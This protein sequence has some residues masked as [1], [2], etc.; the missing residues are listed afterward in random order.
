MFVYKIDEDLS[1]RLLNTYDA[2]EFFQLMDTSRKH[3]SKW[4]G[5]LDYNKEVNDSKAFIEATLKSI[6]DTGG[7]PKTVAMIYKGS[8]AGVIGFN[9][10]NHSNKSAIIGY[11]IGEKFQGKGI[12]TKACNALIVYGFNDIRLNRMEIRVAKENY[13]S[14]AIPERLGFKE[15]GLIRH[16][17]WLYDHYVDHVV[18]GLLKEE[19]QA[20]TDKDFNQKKLETR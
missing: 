13:K 12:V 11:W 8:I 5:W 19:W 2:E 1:L 7:F 15:E 18:Y 14:R 17:E 20:L 10:I 3:L 6:A 16:A 4:L 9:E